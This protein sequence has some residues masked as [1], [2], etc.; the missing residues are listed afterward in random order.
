MFATCS[1]LIAIPAFPGSVAAV[2]TMANMFT[3]CYA[4]QTIPAFPGSVAAV[5]TMANM[6]QN[7]SALQ[8][9]PAWPSKLSALATISSMFVG[10]TLLQSLPGFPSMSSLTVADSFVS[11]CSTIRSLS[12]DFDYHVLRDRAPTL[13]TPNWTL[14][15]GWSYGTGPNRLIKVAGSANTATALQPTIT[16]TT[17][18]AAD[19]IIDTT[20]PH[21]FQIGD[22]IKFTAITGGAGLKVAIIYKVIATN[23]GANTFMVSDVDDV[24]V[25]FTTN[26]TAGSV[27][28]TDLVITATGV[29][30]VVITSTGRAG[31]ALTATLG[32]AAVGSITTDTHTAYVT[33]TTSAK[34]IFTAA[35]TT[36]ITITGIVIEHMMTHTTMLGTAVS[37]TTSNLTNIRRTCSFASLKMSRLALVQ[38]MNNVGT[39]A[40][41]GQ[42]LTMTGNHGTVDLTA[43]AASLAASPSG[44]VI[45]TATAHGLLAGD[46]VRFSSIT[47]GSGLST[48]TT[49]RVIAAGLGSTTFS[50]SLPP[51]AVETVITF[52][53]NITAGLINRFDLAI[54]QVKGWTTSPAV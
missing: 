22:H 11:G 17:S 21:G 32:G 2:T 30:R 37:F 25:L 46:Y 35:A 13:T 27:W 44:T 47:G 40:P 39:S 23:F 18:L 1:S 41:T 31:T 20:T 6:F 15:T 8:T 12:A 7:C 51:P 19:S 52:T 24:P 49:Y 29:Y 43:A 28:R 5:T 48:L 54:A 42:T 45:N 53:T 26:I 38:M 4:L 9:L 36:A 50:V 16:V 33:A 34:L 10:C 14:T 3:N